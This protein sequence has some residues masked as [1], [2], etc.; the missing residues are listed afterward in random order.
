M[1]AATAG[2]SPSPP[3]PPKP[4]GPGLPLA[5]V[6]PFWLRLSTTVMVVLAVSLPA[7][8]VIFTLPPAPPD[9]VNNPFALTAPYSP[10]SRAQVAVTVL[11]PCFTVKATVGFGFPVDTTTMG[12]CGVKVR[13]VGM[14]VGWD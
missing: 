1:A 7:V 12:F 6:S 11:A 4:P 3:T 13:P 8:A 10:C 2:P 5:L 14:S 9:G